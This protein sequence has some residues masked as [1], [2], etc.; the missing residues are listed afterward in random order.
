VVPNAGPNSTKLIGWMR[1]LFLEFLGFIA[2]S[3][4]NELVISSE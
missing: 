1:M 3:R 2:K 4:P